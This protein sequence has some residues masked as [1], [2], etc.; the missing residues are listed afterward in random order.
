[1]SM[2]R[3]EVWDGWRGMAII[4][5]L[6]GHFFE[7]SFTWIEIGRLGVDAFFA[8]SGML[9]STILFKKRMN[10]RDFYIRRFSRIVPAFS[11]FVLVSFSFAKI[12]NLEFEPLEV[13]TN[14]T[15][16][17]TYIPLEPHIWDTEV[18][19]QHLW[20]LNVE[21]HAYV[22]MSILT[23]F[24][25]RNTNVAFVLIALG[26]ISICICFFYYKNQQLAPAEYR[27]QTETAVSF[28]FL[29][30]G[31]NLLKK[32]LG[33]NIFHYFLPV[34]SLIGA[35]ICYLKIMPGILSFT[36]PPI[37]LAFTINHLHE[38]NKILQGILELKIIR[39]M[40]MWSF[41]I[42]LWQQPFYKF[43]DEIPGE[44]YTSLL[45]AITIGIT[46]FY[47]FEQPIRSRINK[48]WTKRI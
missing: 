34:L 28:V 19:V 38:S 40:G 4:L 44:N 13:V 5:L 23:L 41:S 27:I 12:I 29:S 10:L 7:E 30:A 16:L 3:V 25:F 35:I 48:R 31:Y 6:C 2:N 18:P 8:L 26:L 20:S 43:S 37:L 24:I 22:F 33:N 9:M 15:F 46:S 17:R 11:L 14:L 45:L 39:L 42:Y 36:L 47:F 21:E 1:M 32:D